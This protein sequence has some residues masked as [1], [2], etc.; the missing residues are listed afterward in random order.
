MSDSRRRRRL[1]GGCHDSS[2]LCTG[3]RQGCRA[4]LE[5]QTRRAIRSLDANSGSD[6]R[7]QLPLITCQGRE[8]MNRE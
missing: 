3:V 8:L 4:G 7:K 6:L 2:L 5:H 1:V